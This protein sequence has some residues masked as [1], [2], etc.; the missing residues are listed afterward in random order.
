MFVKI[1]GTQMVNMNQVIALTFDKDRIV[2][3]YTVDGDDWTVE[4]QYSDKVRSALA[5]LNFFYE[6]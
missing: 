6:K 1:N 4:P 3:V 2:R 5:K